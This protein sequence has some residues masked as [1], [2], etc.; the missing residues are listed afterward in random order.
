MKGASQ[1]HNMCLAR[2]MLR[3]GFHDTLTRY[4]SRLSETAQSPDDGLVP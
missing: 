1:Q 2:P 4:D 3:E